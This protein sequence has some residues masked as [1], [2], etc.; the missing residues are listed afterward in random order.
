[1]SL[2][3][4]NSNL[5]YLHIPKTGGKCLINDIKDVVKHRILY[6]HISLP[7]LDIFNEKRFMI[8]ILRN[9]IDRTISEYYHMGIV[10]FNM[11]DKQCNTIE[12]YIK[13]NR[14]RNTQVKFLL[15]YD[16]YD[17]IKITE[18]DVS[19]IKKLIDDKKIYVG[20]LEEWKTYSIYKLLDLPYNDAKIPE[21]DI[22]IKNKRKRNVSSDIREQIK[23]NNKL[24]FMLY[25]YVVDN[26]LYL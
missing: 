16:M 4:K 20:I 26:K 3:I 10:R 9:P 1:M 13:S 17:D 6:Y 21:E 22:K 12:D 24:D 5:V 18:N 7:I 15:G 2:I 11:Y 19:K 25:D 23:E 14:V 8:T